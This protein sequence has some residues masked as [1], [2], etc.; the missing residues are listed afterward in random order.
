[1]SSRQFNKFGQN[2]KKTA[3]FFGTTSLILTHFACLVWFD[4]MI[5]LLTKTSNCWLNALPRWPP[6]CATTT[7]SVRRTFMQS[8]VAPATS[9]RSRF[10]FL[11]ERK[12]WKIP[13]S[14]DIRQTP[15]SPAAKSGLTTTPSSRTPSSLRTIGSVGSLTML[16]TS[17]LLEWWDSFWGPSFSGNFHSFL[18][19]LLQYNQLSVPSRTS[20]AERRASTSGLWPSCSSPSS[21]SPSTTA[22]TCLPCSRWEPAS[23]G[24][25][26]NQQ[27]TL[28][29]N[30]VL[31][32]FG[33]LPL[34]QSPLN[35]LCEICDI[36][37]R[38]KTF[39]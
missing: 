23:D 26:D 1:M 6:L 7:T 29:T 16:L 11:Q 34:F 8:W 28:I 19:F 9:L 37:N 30:Q 24:I 15:S 39:W 13:F 31:A 10:L 12:K 20:L 38:W 21:R 35:I 14:S 22:T 5:S 27:L 2:P 33:M 17:S 18:H 32:T 25:E 4:K 3:A 36:K